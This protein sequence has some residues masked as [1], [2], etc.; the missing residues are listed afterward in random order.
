MASSSKDKIGRDEPV[1]TA[2]ALDYATIARQ[3]ALRKRV[4][5]LAHTSKVCREL[6]IVKIK[7]SYIFYTMVFTTDDSR[8][9]KFEHMI[10]FSRR[11]TE[12]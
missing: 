7:V 2:N 11:K 3:K 5:S 8:S 9:G 12:E 6:T 10:N 1:T 4:V